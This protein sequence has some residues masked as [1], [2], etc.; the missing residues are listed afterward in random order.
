M[1]RGEIE[2]G[3]EE[4]AATER[5]QAVRLLL[6]SPFASDQ[7]SDPETFALVRRHQRW[8]ET[9]FADHLGYR[10]AVDPETA[11]LWKRPAP[12]A[13]VRPARNRASADFDPRRY[14]FFCLLSA[15][16]E[17]TGIQTVLS[18]LAE[19]VQ[20]LAASEPEIANLDLDRYAERQAFVDA[21][22]LLVELGVLHRADGDEQSF[23]DRSGDVLYDVRSRR[24]AQLLASP[25]PPSMAGGPGGIGAEVYPDTE[26][27]AN[28]R[29]RHRLM[30]RL[31][32]EPVLYLADLDDAER[33]YLAKQRPF[34]VKQVATAVGLQVEVRVE[35]LAAVDPEGA[36]SD[37]AFPGTGTVGHAALLLAGFLA[38]RAR[39]AGGD[40]ALVGDGEVASELDALLARYGKLWA[41]AYR[42]DPAGVERLRRE[43]LDRL[44]AMGLVAFH[45]EG[46]EPLPAIA[47]FQA[48]EPR[49]EAGERDG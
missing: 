8:L 28:R 19:I 48:T 24:V 17:R 36:V 5:Q 27:G 7:G 41:R 23:L 10:L 30:R 42:E 37:L 46:I 39:A 34:L 26:D 44:A 47:R 49:G 31:V 40:R 14:A 2:S 18:E 22:R 11:R 32:E 33:A 38:G 6:A 43:A 13:R 20:L 1:D 16:L 35:G 29:I 4:R 25:I 9:W 12:G 45:S 21:A 3:E 15:A